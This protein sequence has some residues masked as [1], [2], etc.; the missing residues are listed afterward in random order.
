MLAKIQY[1]WCVFNQNIQ[2]K[3]ISLGTRMNMF[4]KTVLS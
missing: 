2:N 4:Q 3:V 1:V